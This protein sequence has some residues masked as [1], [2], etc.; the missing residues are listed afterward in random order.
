MLESEKRTS[1]SQQRRVKPE[2]E[3]WPSLIASTRSYSSVC[4]VEF[5]GED[6]LG[7]EDGGKAPVDL[8]RLG[9]DE[10]QKVVEEPRRHPVDREPPKC[11][12]SVYLDEEPPSSS[13]RTINIGDLGRFLTAPT[14]RVA[15]R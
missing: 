12:A 9:L 11:N 15:G 13:V 14:V 3:A 1:R 7:P 2:I 4:T 6:A 10:A 5:R 8:R